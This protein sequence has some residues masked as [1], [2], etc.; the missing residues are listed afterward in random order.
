MKA[1]LIQAKS[2]V[3]THVV[4]AETNSTGSIITPQDS[5]WT[6][7]K[8]YSKT[9]L[10]NSYG[11]W[12]DGPSGWGPG[13]L[14]LSNGYSVTHSYS[15]TLVV[16][17]S[18]VEASVGYAISGSYT[19][20]ASY[21][22]NPPCGEKWKITFREVYKNHKVTQRKYEHIDGQDYWLNEYAYVYTKG[23]LTWDYDYKVI[24]NRSC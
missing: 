20:T 19:Y 8:I 22:V 15:G 16:S 1:L 2:S 11:T 18:S 5:Y 23:F 14:T 4:N 24:D 6:G 10:S 13:T 7:W 17:K 12:K 3:D 9:Q 21:S